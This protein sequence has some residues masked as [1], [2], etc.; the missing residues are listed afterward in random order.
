V[1]A[2]GLTPALT[3]VGDIGGTHSLLELFAAQ[4]GGWRSVHARDFRSGAYASFEALLNDF[5]AQTAQPADGVEAACFSVAGPV[6]GGVSALTNL[7][8]R[9]DA[10]ALGAHY[11]IPEV[12][13]LNDFAAV[14]HGIGTLGEHDVVT[15]QR[16]VPQPRGTR[17]V[18][19]A[20]TGL[21]V[22]VLHWQGDGYAVHASEA[23]HADFA[24]LDAAQD[25]LLADLRGAFGRVSYERVVSGPGLLRIFSH[26]QGAGAGLPSRALLD[27][28]QKQDEAAA[29]S[30]FGVDR[31][32]PLAVRA[33]D[34]FIAV[35][36]AFAGNMALTTLARGGVYIAGGIARQIAAKMADGGFLRAFTDKGRFE[37]LLRR[38]PLHIVTDPK[39]GIKG[40]LNSLRAA[41]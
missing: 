7:D 29:I 38:Y 35:Y 25:A 8:W 19:G 30:A 33:L 40:A 28:M 18:V 16:G 26:L 13:L 32:D 17:L 41:D 34:A 24:P 4:D 31:R 22:C 37:D 14:G 39:I 21:G 9:I 11:R 15:L 23:G 12:R 27:A 3:L 6:E 5:F 1:R 2:R 36:G 10:A 20:G